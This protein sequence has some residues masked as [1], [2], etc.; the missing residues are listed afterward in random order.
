MNTSRPL[1]ANVRLRRAVN[2]AVD[3]PALV[4]LG[5]RFAE[6]NPFNAGEPT[7]G[8]MPAAVAGAPDVHLYPLDH[9]D[10]R[11]A[12]ELAVTSTP[13]RLCTPPTGRPGCRRRRSSKRT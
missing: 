5:R 12:K 2:F 7:D 10:L 4:A 8:Y 6:V 1:F 13:P 3:R 11:R 9:P